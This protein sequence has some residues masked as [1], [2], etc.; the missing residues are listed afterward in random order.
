M[1]AVGLL[2][3]LSKQDRRSAEAIFLEKARLLRKAASS[4]VA[5]VSGDDLLRCGSISTKNQ[6]IN[7]IITIIDDDHL[8]ELRLNAASRTVSDASIVAV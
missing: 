4:S 3:Q 1:A 7:D 2:M 5:F 6:R 8:D